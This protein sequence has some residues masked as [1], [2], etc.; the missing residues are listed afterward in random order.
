MPG[1][2]PS[3]PWHA[4][5]G[6]PGGSLEPT[7][8]QVDADAFDLCAL[9]FEVPPH[10]STTPAGGG[11]FDSSLSLASSRRAEFVQPS[12][13]GLSLSFVHVQPHNVSQP[14]GSRHAAW[15]CSSSRSVAPATV[16]SSTRVFVMPN[17]P[18]MKH[19][20]RS[21]P[22]Q[23]V[24]RLRTEAYSARRCPT[25]LHAALAVRLSHFGLSLSHVTTCSCSVSQLPWVWPVPNSSPVIVAPSTQV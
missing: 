13:F 10:E 21:L 20:T 7:H 5:A 3:R 6:A 24:S 8:T 14:S 12:Q 22:H 19:R 11:V 2:I 9:G 1:G 25:C 15:P 17:T 18:P 23:G 16:D 4:G